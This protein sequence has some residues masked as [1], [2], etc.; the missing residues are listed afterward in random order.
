MS[1]QEHGP[2]FRMNRD[3]LP[4]GLLQLRARLFAP[5]QRLGW[6][7][8]DRRQFATPFSEP[9]PMRLPVP[10]H[11]IAEREAAQQRFRRTRLT[12][13]LV[14]A[15]LLAF[16]GLVAG[17][18]AAFPGTVN[19][20]GILLAAVFLCVPGAVAAVVMAG[21]SSAASRAVEQAE[22]DLAVGYQRQAMAWTERKAAHERAEQARVDALAEWGAARTPAGTRRIDVF[23]GT[24]HG[25]EAFLTVYGTSVLAERPVL[26]ADFSRELICRELALISRAAGAPVDVQVLPAQLAESS[27]LAGLLPEQLA[28]ALVESMH[29]DDAASTRAQ[30]SIDGRILGAVCAALGEP[31]SIARVAAALRVLM[32]E[33]D[34]SG[35]LTADERTRIADGL[36]TPEYLRQV[37]PDLVRIES[38]V[39]PLANLGSAH[40][41]PSDPAQSRDPA[42]LT[43]IA[44]QPGATSVQ[45]ELLADIAVQ[46]ITHRVA[47]ASA[48]APAVIIAGADEIARRHLERLSDACERRNVLLTLLFR[49][50]RD[51]SADLLGGGAA[52]FMRLGNP[53]EA[54]RAAAF[55]G[56]EHKFVLSQVTAS[57]GGSETHTAEVSESPDETDTINPGTGAGWLKGLGAAG[58]AGLGGAA[59]LALLR[60]AGGAAG[61]KRAT[62][63][64]W[65][66]AYARATETNWSEAQA[67]QRVYEYA[68]EPTTLQHL[69]DY[70]MLLVTSR[71]GGGHSVAAVECNPEIVTLP[72]VSTDPLPEPRRAWISESAGGGVRPA[73]RPR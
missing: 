12:A 2:S 33:K 57:V 23:G 38:H 54:A 10:P 55:I 19:A 22:R 69:P 66:A 65:S 1:L 31:A 7:F 72:R 3:L 52:G 17:C 58:L 64:T 15:G 43:C 26:V 53:E 49:H 56:R 41:S 34:Q 67:A 37:H 6:I 5:G 51:A 48:Q 70:A 20:G 28:A 45:D 32:G 27:V 35:L 8:R 30:R 14:G 39:H 24:L 61:G 63:R 18:A 46:W 4:H 44:L 50:V 47:G 71:R 11:L 42:Y 73:G 36:F 25:W 40:A 13:I 16:F 62:G 29:P 21:R 9:P 59:G 68:V 60:G